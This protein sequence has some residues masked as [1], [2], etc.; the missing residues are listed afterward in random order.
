M[1]GILFTW[2]RND[3]S[4]RQ[5]GGARFQGWN[6]RFVLAGT[7][8]PFGRMGKPL[9]QLG[10][11]V[12]DAWAPG[13]YR[14]WRMDLVRSAPPKKGEG[15]ASRCVL[16]EG[17]R[18]AGCPLPHLPPPL[19]PTFVSRVVV[20]KTFEHNVLPNNFGRHLW[21]NLFIYLIRRR[22]TTVDT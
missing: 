7:E 4:K 18:Q 19:H 12:L 6:G 13:T 10:A 5:Q 3:V 8:F 14:W 15:V 16:H 20:I 17:A 2:E 9:R 11:D 1:D 22:R 21:E